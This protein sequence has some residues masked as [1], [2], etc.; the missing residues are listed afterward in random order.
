MYHQQIT[1]DLAVLFPIIPLP[2]FT[3]CCIPLAI[4]EALGVLSGTAIA[5][6]NFLA[7]L[8]RMDVRLKKKKGG[9]KQRGVAGK[10]LCDVAITLALGK[11]LENR[12]E[13][14]QARETVQSRRMDVAMVVSHRDKPGT[15]LP[16]QIH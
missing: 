15:R 1:M 8:G 6:L 14:P 7:A 10:P 4:R 13:G 5:K 3:S 11:S 16:S 2:I 9:R 12:K